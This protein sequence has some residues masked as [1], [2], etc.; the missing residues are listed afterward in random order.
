[1]DGL[2]LLIGL[3]QEWSYAMLIKK[4]EV[5]PILE[6]AQKVA[7]DLDVYEDFLHTIQFIFPYFYELDLFRNNHD[8]SA[9]VPFGEAKAAHEALMAVLDREEEASKTAEAKIAEIVGNSE[10]EDDDFD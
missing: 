10:V 3:L 1:M 6:Y 7:P 9:M 5:F 4:V 2:G 8:K